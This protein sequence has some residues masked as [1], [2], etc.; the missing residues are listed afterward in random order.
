MQHMKHIAGTMCS[1]FH[2][3]RIISS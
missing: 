1:D 3:V 2:Y